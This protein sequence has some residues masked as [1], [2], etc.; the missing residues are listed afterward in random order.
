[1][2]QRLVCMS[3]F[4]EKDAVILM[5]LKKKREGGERGFVR[6]WAILPLRKRRGAPRLELGTIKRII[7]NGAWESR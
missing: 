1:M 6:C 7:V 4:L 2:Q 5:I 3:R